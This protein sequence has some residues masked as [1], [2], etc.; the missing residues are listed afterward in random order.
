[1]NSDLI[2]DVHLVKLIDTTYS[3]VS[4]HQ[5]TS[6]KTELSSLRI[7][8]DTCCQTSGVGSLAAAVNSAGE[9]LADVLEELRLGG[10]WVTNDADVY[11]TSKLN[12][13]CCVLFNAAKQLQ[14]DAFFDVQM[15][16]DTRGNRF[17]HLRV[18]VVLVFHVNNGVLFNL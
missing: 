1:M 6:F 4:K 13:V 5:G 10:G 14:Q 11:I 8:A 9:E 3:V 17:S 12:L 15:A 16:V 7:F 2:L 18:K